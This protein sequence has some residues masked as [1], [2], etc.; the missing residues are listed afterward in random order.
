MTA[1]LLHR[2]DTFVSTFGHP[3]LLAAG[4]I[5]LLLS[6]YCWTVKNRERTANAV[7]L[8]SALR[9]QLDERGATPSIAGLRRRRRS[10]RKDHAP[11]E[12]RRNQSQ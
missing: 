12:K 4:T 9:G 5:A 7:K 10:T 11:N 3:G 6:V 8:I 2:L 1:S